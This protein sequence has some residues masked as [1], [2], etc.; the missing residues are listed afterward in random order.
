MP[1]PD[2]ERLVESLSRSHLNLIET[3]EGIDLNTII[4]E[5]STWRIRD[6]LWHIAAWDQQVT[7]S[8]LAFNENSEYSIPDFDE[9]EFN[10][11]AYLEGIKLDEP[12]LLDEFNQARQDF[13]NAVQ[14]FPVEKL[15]S[16]FL[17]PWG[18]ERGDITQLVN[19]MIKHDEEHR[20][21][22][23]RGISPD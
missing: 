9:D 1:D 15:S 20:D 21:E 11:T 14:K 22:I 3:V 4:Y 23:V 5:I 8:I 16:D 17:Y 19:Y 12:H 10:Q 6:I 18:D 13:K 7:K 2:V